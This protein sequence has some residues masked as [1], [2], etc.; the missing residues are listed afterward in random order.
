[1]MNANHEESK[2]LPFMK[3]VHHFHHFRMRAEKKTSFLPSPFLNLK[4]KF[5]SI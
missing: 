4:F 5:N 1:M 2:S 3:K